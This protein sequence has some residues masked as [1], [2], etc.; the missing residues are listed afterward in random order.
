MSDPIILDS[1]ENDCYKDNNEKR[2]KLKKKARK[3]KYY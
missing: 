3:N 2:L 1:S